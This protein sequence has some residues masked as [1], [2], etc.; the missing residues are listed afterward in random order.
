M[1]SSF[2]NS[3]NL[4]YILI[5]IVDLNLFVKMVHTDRLDFFALLKKVTVI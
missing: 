1:K 3:V 5:Q 2:C 4:I